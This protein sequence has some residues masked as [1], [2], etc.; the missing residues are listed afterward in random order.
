MNLS[1]L[2]KQDLVEKFESDKDQVGNEMEGAGK[3]LASAK[4]MLGID[5]WEWAHAAAYNAMLHAGRA[6]MF[7]KGY[8]P[9]GHDHHIAVVNY[10]IAVFSAKFPED[11]LGYFVRGRKL[12]HE[13]M[14]DK[15]DIITSDKAAKMVE[16]A[17]AF[18]NK[19]KEIMKI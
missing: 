11:V 6:L 13:F 10:T 9:K 7:Y 15:V 8:R 14:Y 4:N 1:D 5:E 2:L 18:V 19:A 3:N 12:R 17:E 16:K